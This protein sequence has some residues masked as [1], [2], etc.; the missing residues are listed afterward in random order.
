MEK[1]I[2]V[3]VHSF[4]CNA[5]KYFSQLPPCRIHIPMVTTLWAC[6]TPLS[7]NTVSPHGF[8]YICER[9]TGLIPFS[10]L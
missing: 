9:A 5:M 3:E 2:H 6:E 4:F 8:F 1:G 10:P 7:G